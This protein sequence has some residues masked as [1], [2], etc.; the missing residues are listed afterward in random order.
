MTLVVDTGPLVALADRDD[1][2]RPIIGRLLH[3]E[4]SA[5]VIPAP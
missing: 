3:H 4:V 1:R 2:L 5:L